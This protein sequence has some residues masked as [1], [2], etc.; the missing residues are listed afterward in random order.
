MMRDEDGIYV[1]LTVSTGT[2]LTTVPEVS[3]YDYR[4]A[5]LLLQN[6]GFLVEIEN[7]TSD[8]VDKDKVISISP[9]AG[10]K[11]SAGST[12]YVT[13]SSGSQLVL[14]TM[15]NLIGLTE[16]AAI[17][18]LQKL[19]LSYGG[20]EKRSSEYE[21]GTVIGQS[22]NAFAQVEEH[23]KIYLVVSSGMG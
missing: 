20:T 12:V 3:G 17:K 9:S 6:A 15:P 4:E 14:I 8:S 1:K 10:E 16:D 19:G 13:V 22:T 5:V 7:V 18:K 2:I 23:A 21:P 11:I